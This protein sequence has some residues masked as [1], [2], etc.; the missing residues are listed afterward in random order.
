M[1][2]YISLY[3]KSIITQVE[4]YEIPFWYIITQKE[5][6]ILFHDSNYTIRRFN[7]QLCNSKFDPNLINIRNYLQRI[8]Y[9]LV[10]NCKFKLD[11]YFYS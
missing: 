10:I 4:Q 9:M 5:K 3:L 11:F 2:S 7:I 6:N 1:H 8:E